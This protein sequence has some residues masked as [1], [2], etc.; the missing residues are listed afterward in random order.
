LQIDDR[1][2]EISTANKQ[3]H[4]KV[5]AVA[6]PE[7]VAVLLEKSRQQLKSEPAKLREALVAAFK[8]AGWASDTVDRIWSFGPRRCGPNILLNRIKGH[9]GTIW[10][11]EG[12][13]GG[14]FVNGF[15]LASLAGPLCE[16]P[17]MG[18]CFIVQKFE[19]EYV[20]YFFTI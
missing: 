19:E 17:M 4:L 3:V 15:Q 1:A 14:N 12:P 16:E 6:L 10:T 11:E 7:E 5:L 13:Y 8:T 2:V 18:V 20:Y 9:C